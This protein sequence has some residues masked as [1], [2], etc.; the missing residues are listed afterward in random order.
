M[1]LRFTSMSSANTS[2]YAEWVCEARYTRKDVRERLSRLRY[3][4]YKQKIDWCSRINH[5]MKTKKI[6]APKKDFK[7]GGGLQKR[8]IGY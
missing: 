1:T 6:T 3:D 5:F 4:Y 2:F 8:P 7:K